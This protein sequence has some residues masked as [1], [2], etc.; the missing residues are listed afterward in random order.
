MS[1]LYRILLA[2]ALPVGAVIG[3]LLALAIIVLVGEV[4]S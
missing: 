2:A 1:L 4:A 3:C